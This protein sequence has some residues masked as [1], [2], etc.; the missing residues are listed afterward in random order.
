MRRVCIVLAACACVLVVVPAADAERVKPPKKL[1]SEYPLVPKVRVRVAA[2]SHPLRPPV[3][4]VADSPPSG[5][6]SGWILTL[7][8]AAGGVVVVL[9]VARPLVAS[10][11]RSAG[12]V[13]RPR[14][15]SRPR[16]RAGSPHRRPA[17]VQYAPLQVGPEPERPSES[18]PY[19]TRRS[20]VL[21]SR[22]VVMVEEEGRTQELR[23][24]KP[25][26]QVGREAWQRGWAEDAWDRLSND[27][28]AE[29][30]EVDAS[31]R[32]EYFVPLRRALVSSLEPYSRLGRRNAPGR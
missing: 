24:S 7:A 11:G 14:M 26:W 27:L 5:G 23:R 32:Y 1:W 6:R 25:F 4:T 12:R 20:G 28:R 10:R 3:A 2:P 15:P 9:A 13:P 30:W 16:R 8:L 18:V 19:I 17:V 21:R 31:G 22:Y 29:G